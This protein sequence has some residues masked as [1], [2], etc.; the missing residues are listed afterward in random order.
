MLV[1]LSCLLQ[2]YSTTGC[3][4]LWVVKVQGYKKQRVP[5]INYL[6][7]TAENLDDATN[8]EFQFEA[9]HGKLILWV[10]CSL[11]ILTLTLALTLT[12]LISCTLTFRWHMF[13]QTLIRQGFDQ[14]VAWV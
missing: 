13:K 12:H 10:L 9:I 3:T 5:S 11:N 2:V 4:P 8:Q 7:S 14:Q 6:H 1:L